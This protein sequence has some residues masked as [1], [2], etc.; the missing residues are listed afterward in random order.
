MIFLEKKI[1]LFLGRWKESLQAGYYTKVD[2]F[3]KTVSGPKILKRKLKKT[4]SFIFFFM[5]SLLQGRFNACTSIKKS[6]FT[7]VSA[8]PNAT[9]CG[10]AYLSENADSGKNELKVKLFEIQSEFIKKC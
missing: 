6:I 2:K 10:P 8:L 9:S 7:E 1:R 5:Q 3:T 4:T